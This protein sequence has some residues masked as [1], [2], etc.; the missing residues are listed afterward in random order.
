MTKLIIRSFR[1]GSGKRVNVREMVDKFTIDLIGQVVYGVK[2]NSLSEP[3]ADFWKYAKYMFGSYN[4]RRAIELTCVSLTPQIATFFDFR[5]FEKHSSQFFSKAFQEI[6]DER[7]SKKINR[8]DLIDL[9]IELKDNQEISDDS[10]HFS[11]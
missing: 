2:L 5:L 4:L 7:I 3:N 11:K 10:H 9:L 6:L 8:N 1:T